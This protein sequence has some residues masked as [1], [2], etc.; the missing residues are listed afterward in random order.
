MSIYSVCNIDS[1]WPNETN[2]QPLP[3]TQDTPHDSKQATIRVPKPIQ[4]IEMH[5]NGKQ[6]KT[7][8]SNRR[9]SQRDTRSKEAKEEEKVGERAVQHNVLFVIMIV[10]CCILIAQIIIGVLAM[11]YI[12]GMQTILL[13]CMIRA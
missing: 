2:P 10:V 11:H 8:N 7:N 4:L 13:Q 9:H 1:A 12:H 3:K 6:K 5:R